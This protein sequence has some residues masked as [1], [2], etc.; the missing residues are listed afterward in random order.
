MHRNLFERSAI[1]NWRLVVGSACALKALW[2]FI[3]CVPIW[4]RRH[5]MLGL[6]PNHEWTDYGSFCCFLVS[7]YDMIALLR[8]CV[9]ILLWLCFRLWLTVPYSRDWSITKPRPPST[10]GGT[11]NRCLDS[12]SR[13]RT[14]PW[15]SPQPCWGPLRYCFHYSVHSF[16]HE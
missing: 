2:T 9:F 5:V 11:K 3:G 12:I 7:S 15:S 6:K 10:N 13:A 1:A 16:V 4:K 14:M 8:Q